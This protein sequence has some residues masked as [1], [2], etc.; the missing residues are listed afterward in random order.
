MNSKEEI[1]TTTNSIPTYWALEDGTI[2]QKLIDTSWIRYY[3][4]LDGEPINNIENDLLYTAKKIDDP[5]LIEKIKMDPSYEI[6][7]RKWLN[8]PILNKTITKDTINNSLSSLLDNR[9]KQFLQSHKEQIQQIIPILEAIP[10]DAES[11]E[12]IFENLIH[13]QINNTTRDEIIQ[14]S[15][16]CEQK[17]DYFLLVLKIVKTHIESLQYTAPSVYNNGK[18]YRND[19]Y[20]TLE[21]IQKE[22]WPM[23]LN[24]LTKPNPTLRPQGYN[25]FL[26]YVDKNNMT[27]LS[28]LKKII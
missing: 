4:K 7:N 21:T 15:K 19:F 14:I 2:V 9:T 5:A 22:D 20:D 25:D 23:Q 10:L 18:K 24:M 11:Q 13:S 3:A 1:N 26:D 16:D 28:F 17:N 6:R 12:R 8:M 27:V